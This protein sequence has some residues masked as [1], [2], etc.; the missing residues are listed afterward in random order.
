MVAC[1]DPAKGCRRSKVAFVSK[2]EK[3]S[4]VSKVPQVPQGAILI[5]PRAPGVIFHNPRGPWGI[6]DNP[7]RTWCPLAKVDDA[8]TAHV[9]ISAA[10]HAHQQFEQGATIR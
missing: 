4:K 7:Q 8:H 10:G 6:F 5:T 9:V 2:V 1:F 3:F